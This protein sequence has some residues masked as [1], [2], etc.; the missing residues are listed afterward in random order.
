MKGEGKR[1][2]ESEG[3]GKARRRETGNKSEDKDFFKS[4]FVLL[5]LITDLQ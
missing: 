2:K 4:L 1:L 3:A 5:I